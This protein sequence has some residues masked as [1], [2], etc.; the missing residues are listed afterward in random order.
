MATGSDKP[1]SAGVGGQATSGVATSCKAVV[2]PDT[3]GKAKGKAGPARPAANR[4][5]EPKQP[6]ARVAASN[7]ADNEGEITASASA[8]K[9]KQGVASQEDSKAQGREAAAIPKVGDV[10]PA[11][12]DVSL[13]PPLPTPKAP[14][15]IVAADTL[16]KPRPPRPISEGLPT[17]WIVEW[18]RSRLRWYFFHTATKQSSWHRPG[19][20]SGNTAPHHGKEEAVEVK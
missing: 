2:E 4:D 11:A 1:T 16:E 12:T 5:A 8:D 19:E 18:S 7:A 10:S 17:G 14:V 6:M 13:E 9:A 15:T 3:G 20:N